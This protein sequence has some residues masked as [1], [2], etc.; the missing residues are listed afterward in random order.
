MN[1]LV[2]IPDLEEI[3]EV[4][5]IARNNPELLDGRELWILENFSESFEDELEEVEIE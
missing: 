1:L 4:K 5:K 2:K 3:K